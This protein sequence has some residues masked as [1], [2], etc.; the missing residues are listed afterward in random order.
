MKKS[1]L[2]VA[3]VMALLLVGCN[4]EGNA[5]KAN[6]YFKE[7]TFN[8]SVTAKQ[9]SEVQEKLLE[10]VLNIASITIKGET[11]RKDNLVET[12]I[13]TK[14]TQKILEDSS[15]KDLLILEGSGETE[16]KRVADGITFEEKVKEK[17][18]EWDAGNGYRFTVEEATKNGKTEKEH[19]AYALAEDADHKAYKENR[20][21][22]LMNMASFN[23]DCYLDA[24]GNYVFIYSDVEREV[25]GVQ[26]G[27]SVKE[28]V[29]AARTQS[30]YTVDKNYQLT[31]YY[32]YHES[33]TNRDQQTGEWYDKEQIVSYTY[34]EAS[35]D[36]GNREA[37]KIA[38]LNTSIES[39][40]FVLNL[41]AN[42]YGADA[43]VVEAT[44]ATNPNTYGITIDT[45][46]ETENF[47]S[48][49]GDRENGKYILSVEQRLN[50]GYDNAYA[51]RYKVVANVMTGANKSVE[52]K[53][54]DLDLSA[55]AEKFSESNLCRI[56]KAEN[57]KYYAVNL[58]RYTLL[59]RMTVELDGSTAKVTAFNVIAY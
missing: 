46:H 3:F 33:V 1:F 7:Y 22:G 39:Q 15:K 9:V 25:S 49:N 56:H 41:S 32:V 18:T 5:A 30:V 44:G 38:T 48:Y 51:Q 42:Y 2:G 11:Y 45:A 31:S 27:T 28:Y 54:F 17:A 4:K 53:E 6:N 58:V 37:A 12:T 55:Y 52:E 21:K 14:A 19:N 20:I 40:K 13:N 59:V 36:Y 23:Y 10:N 43:V 26:W 50:F 35:F 47:L 34:A 29:E 16:T 24:K 57:N 8:E